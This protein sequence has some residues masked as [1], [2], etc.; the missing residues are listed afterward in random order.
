MNTVPDFVND[1]VRRLMRTEDPAT[2]PLISK[3]LATYISQSCDLPVY[4]YDSLD[5]L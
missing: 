4:H 1:I 5:S 2:L 3:L